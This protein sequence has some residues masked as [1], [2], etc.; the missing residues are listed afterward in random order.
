MSRV[1]EMELENWRGYSAYELA[2][3]NGFKGTEQEWLDTLQGR[4]GGTSSVNDVPCDEKGNIHLTAEH[5]PAGED[6]GRSMREIVQHV[7]ELSGAI[8]VTQDALDVGGRYL[9]NALFR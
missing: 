3:R 4:D 1:I 5:I 2:V 7:D 6:D 9:D 8:S